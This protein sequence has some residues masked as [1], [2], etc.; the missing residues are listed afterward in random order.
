MTHDRSKSPDQQPAD[1]DAE[2]ND[3][4]AAL[5]LLD[6]PATLYKVMQLMLRH[7]ELDYAQLWDFVKSLPEAE[8]LTRA[9]LDDA[10]H[11]L[12]EQHWL[13]HGEDDQPHVYRVN[14]RR[15]IGNV[16]STFTPQTKRGTTVSHGIWDALDAESTPKRINL[17]SKDDDSHSDQG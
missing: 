5:D 15:K 12:I 14:F 6:L 17:D 13:L 2:R 10:L 16:R 7:L 4:L 1:N 8:R 11:N 3:G 9:E